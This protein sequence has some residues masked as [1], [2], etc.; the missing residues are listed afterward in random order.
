LRNRGVKGG[1]R[2]HVPSHSVYAGPKKKKVTFEKKLGGGKDYR[3]V[4]RNFLLPCLYILK[5]RFTDEHK[6]QTL[7]VPKP[8]RNVTFKRNEQT[9]LAILDEKKEG[10][11]DGGI[12]R[13]GGGAKG[14][15]KRNR[16]H[17]R[18]SRHEVRDAHPTRGEGQQAPT[19]E[20]VSILFLKT[21]RVGGKSPVKKGSETRE[22]CNTSGGENHPGAVSCLGTEGKS[23]FR[24]C[25]KG[26]L[27]Y[28][29]R[30]V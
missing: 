29:K 30:E 2:H 8:G 27:C 13:S 11:K 17:P 3:F 21:G 23:D 15:G 28:Y 22:P 19:K 25:E 1:K 24:I 14:G 18:Q 10:K 26:R 4:K 9:R 16:R 7:A 5:R 20:Q 6:I 12:G